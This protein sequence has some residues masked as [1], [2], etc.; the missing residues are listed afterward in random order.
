[1]EIRAADC[2]FCQLDNGIRRLGDSGLRAFLQLDITNSSIYKGPHRGVRS[3]ANWG[4]KNVAVRENSGSSEGL[5]SRHG[6]GRLQVE[7][8]KYVVGQ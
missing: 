6:V 2:G 5:H 3:L 8:R 1:M 7:L 4:S